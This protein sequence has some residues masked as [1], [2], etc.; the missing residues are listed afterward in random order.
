MF[1][2]MFKL[3]DS[4]VTLWSVTN[5]AYFKILPITAIESPNTRREKLMNEKYIRNDFEIIAN[6]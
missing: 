3:I 5:T 4:M 1:K 6:K 2:F